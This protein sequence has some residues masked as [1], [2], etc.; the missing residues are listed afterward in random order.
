MEMMWLMP[1]ESEAH[2]DFAGQRADGGRGDDVHA[3]LLLLAGIIQA[4]LFLGELQAAAARSDDHADLAQLLARQRVRRQRRRP[5][6]LPAP[7]RRPAE[8]RAKRAGGP[9][10]RRIGVSSKPTTSPATCTGE[11]QGSKRVMRRTPLTPLRLAS[12]KASLPIPLGLTAP[13]PVMTTRRFICAD[14]LPLP[15]GQYR[16]ISWAMV[17]TPG[18]NSK[19]AS[20]LAGLEAGILAALTLLGWL[21]L[22]SAWYRHSI[23][24]AANI[25][26]TNFY[27]E[28][29][30]SR[31]F[32]FRTVAG[33]ALYLVLYGDHRRSI[34]SHP[35]KP[36]RQSPHHPD[37]SAGG[38]RLV[39]SVVRYPVAEHRSTH[40]TV[41]P[42]R[43]HGGG[44]CALR[45]SAGPFSALSASRPPG[46]RGS[47]CRSIAQSIAPARAMK[48]RKQA[49]REFLAAGPI[50]AIGE[51][52]WRG[53]AARARAGI[54]KLPARSAA[55]RPDCR[56]RNL[57]RESGRNR[58][59]NW[60]AICV[61][62][63]RFTTEAM[64]AGDRQRAR[65]CRRQVIAAKD[66]ARFV[67]AAA[68]RRRPRRRRRRRR[69]R[70]GCSSGWK[71][72]RYFRPGSRSASAIRVPPI[73]PE[74]CRRP[75]CR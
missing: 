68:P 50:T 16:L 25:M 70:S 54:G 17:R 53:G 72:P 56:S 2:G 45:R 47:A 23:W 46:C 62:C 35:R 8:P 9:W 73:P 27:G 66:R 63:W 41:H 39:L 65:Y 40:S 67:A 52:E 61:T 14:V 28:A 36:R 32:T 55:R 20:L 42:S 29:A 71:I 24:T 33:I 6:W 15:I 13:I 31:D 64:R 38:S 21:A 3:A 5:P 22:A 7:R 48:S 69:W 49:L 57:M 1:A 75:A 4:V 51:A 11:P 37:R 18:N 58:F 59:A 12:Q 26:A 10:D 60:S 19:G 44:P 43:A 74:R 30:L 34:R